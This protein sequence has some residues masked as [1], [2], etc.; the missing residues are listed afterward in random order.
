MSVFAFAL[1]V[2]SATPPPAAGGIQILKVQCQRW[3]ADATN[4][5]A[6]AHGIKVLGPSFLAS[7]G[8]KARDVIIHDFLKQNLLP[9]GGTGIGAPYGFARYAPDGTPIEPHT[10]LNIKALISDAHA[11]LSTSFKTSWGTLTLQQLVRSARDGFRHSPT[12]PDYWRDV[13]WTLS[14]LADTEK[15]GAQWETAD[16]QHIRLDDVFEE[17]LLELERETSDLK[18][19]LEQH[20]PQVDKRKQGL[21]SHS[22]GGMHFVQ[23]VLA[24]AKHPAIAKRWKARLGAQIAI[25]FYR[26]ES[27]RRQYDAA[28]QETL[29]SA[30][31]HT[32]RVLIQMV[33]FYGHWLETAAHFRDDLGWKPTADQKHDIARARVYLD[34]AVR[35]LEERQVFSVMGQLKNTQ[36][37]MYLDLIG[38]SC[39]A[40]HGVAAWPL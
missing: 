22:C 5:W 20:L 33:K 18:A 13:G 25:H 10:N 2:A 24:W 7:D 19:G 37:Q 8:R 14:L 23:G 17:A 9:D 29:S 11:K 34:A 6:L 32:L 30:P 15:P 40:A 1:L 27:E 3:A 12:Q 28:Y 26:L 21:Y 36:K 16:G 38:D 4:P 39:H 31:Q 35:I